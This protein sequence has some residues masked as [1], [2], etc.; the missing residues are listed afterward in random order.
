[1]LPPLEFKAW[2]STE[3]NVVA[4]ARV[5]SSLPAEVVISTVGTPGVRKIALSNSSFPL[6]L[7][8]PTRGY[9][10]FMQYV[11]SVFRVQMLRTGVRVFRNPKAFRAYVVD[12]SSPENNG[13]SQKRATGP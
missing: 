6:S 2:I 3:T 7:M 9:S 11:Y 5:S 8:I 4:P 1:M 10:V 13:I 12:A